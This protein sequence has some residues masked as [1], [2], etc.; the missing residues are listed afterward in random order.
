MTCEQ[1]ILD[2]SSSGNV[3][4]GRDIYDA[5]GR[6]NISRQSINTILARMSAAGQ[7][8]RVS[9][10]KYSTPRAQNMFAPVLSS[11][12]TLLYNDIRVKYPFA[13]VCVYQ[14]DWLSHLMH[15]MATNN[16]IYIE[17]ERDVADVVFD[18]LRSQGKNA[19]YRPD[20]E[21][22]YRY[23]DLS[24]QPYIVKILTTQSP[25]SKIG[26][27]PVPTL[28]KLLVDL[29]CDKDFNY[30]QGAEYYHIMNAAQNL[31]ELNIPSM[32]RYASRR[33]V[34]EKIAKIMEESKNDIG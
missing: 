21:I 25:L 24:A 16:A 27:V 26:N 6:D 14:G 13:A 9:R 10:G 3:F 28:E 5:I 8:E 19:Y 18:Y 34:K 2:F 15:H 11:E 12:A 30:L 7:I 22:M 29:Y 33:N 17:V 4:T 23:V 32:L 20:K 31:Y 1:Y